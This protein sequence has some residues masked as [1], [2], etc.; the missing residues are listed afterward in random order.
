MPKLFLSVRIT[1]NFFTNEEINK[2]EKEL[3]KYNNKSEFLRKII[4][5][6]LQIEDNE[7][8]IN[9][10]NLNPQNSNYNKN[11]EE[12]KILI[13]ENHK[14][15]QKLSSSEIQLKS[16]NYKEPYKGEEQEVQ[17]EK[18]LGLLNQF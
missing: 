3:K 12:L 5:F 1:E 4:K 16:D 13:E 8:L 15:L 7:S 17:T 10:S 9:D 2:I 18:I 6:Y 11:L 14:I